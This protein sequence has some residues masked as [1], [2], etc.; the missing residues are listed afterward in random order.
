MLWCKNQIKF[1][2]L[3]EIKI[4]YFYVIV[5][6]WTWKV[7]SVFESE[8]PIFILCCSWYFLSP[9]NVTQIMWCSNLWYYLTN[10]FSYLFSLL[11]KVGFFTKVKMF[12]LDINY[13]L[14]TKL[15]YLFNISP[16]KMV[17]KHDCFETHISSTFCQTPIM[18][19][20]RTALWRAYLSV[21]D[22]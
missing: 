12:L 5:C 10:N 7:Y 3:Y 18:N 21:L 4:A 6:M 9:T 20:M 15:L 22:I 2:P 14:F 13:F 16:R 8:K 17:F 19:L 11:W 1:W